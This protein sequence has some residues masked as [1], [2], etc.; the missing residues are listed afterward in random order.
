MLNKHGKYLVFLII[1]TIGAS[2]VTSCKKE[3]GGNIQILNQGSSSFE[4]VP[5]TSEPFHKPDVTT[6]VP[7]DDDYQNVLANTKKLPIYCIN[8]NAND[9]ETVEV[10]VEQKAEI[11]AP[12]VVEKVIEEFSN[13]D[14]V[15]QTDDVSQDDEGNVTV[16]FTKDC[17][18]VEGVSKKVEYLI[19][20][21]ISQSILD[22]VETS[23]AVIF[24]REGDAYKTSHIVLGKNE[25]YN[26]K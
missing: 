1:M 24:Q 10:M 18:P 16:S 6:E 15:I 11:D 13:H 12:I 4:P 22:N 19:L 5:G 14:L 8:D 7:E 3:D 23:S 20:D 2:F 26:W 21:C 25:A 17:A 9:I